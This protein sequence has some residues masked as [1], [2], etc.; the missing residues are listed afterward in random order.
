MSDKAEEKKRE[1]G[2]KKNT[3]VCFKCMVS[4]VLAVEIIIIKKNN[5]GAL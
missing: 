4:N 2:L 5:L 1:K 3:T